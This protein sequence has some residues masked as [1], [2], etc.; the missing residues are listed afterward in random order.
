[1]HL[2][3]M[4]RKEDDNDDVDDD[5]DDD[6]DSGKMIN[7]DDSGNDQ[8]SM[9]MMFLLWKITQLFVAVFVQQQYCGLQVR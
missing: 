2:P 8:W 7:G 3:D 6:D 5:D 4:F 1:M 9:K